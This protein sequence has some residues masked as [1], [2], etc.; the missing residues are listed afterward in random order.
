[1]YLW[2]VG[3]YVFDIVLEVMLCVEGVVEVMLICC[4]NFRY[5]YWMM[6]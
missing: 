3:K 4:M 2:Y 5:M 1:M 6:V